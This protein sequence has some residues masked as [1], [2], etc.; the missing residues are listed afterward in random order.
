MYAQTINDVQTKNI[1]MESDAGASDSMN[2]SSQCMVR[3][4]CVGSSLR[5]KSR[6]QPKEAGLL[7]VQPLS[8]LYMPALSLFDACG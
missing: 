1:N 8:T 7:R 4:V 3:R 6:V 5:K 2:T